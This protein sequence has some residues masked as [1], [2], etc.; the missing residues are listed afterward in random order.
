VI[1]T[2]QSLRI[3]RSR[4]PRNEAEEEKLRLKKLAKKVKAEKKGAMRELR[5]D[6]YAIQIEKL[7]K[8]QEEDRLRKEKMEQI[9]SAL[10]RE[11]QEFSG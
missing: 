2:S 5:K 3:D 6:T 4:K 11:Q 7:R 1:V 9:Q 10:A 8:Q